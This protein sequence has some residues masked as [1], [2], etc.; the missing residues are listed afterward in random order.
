VASGSPETVLTKALI[1]SVYTARVN[2]I[3]GGDGHP[4]VAPLRSPE[5]EIHDLP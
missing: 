5:Q 1:E 3:T 2:V 4:V